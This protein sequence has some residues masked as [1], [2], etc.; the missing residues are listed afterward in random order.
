MDVAAGEA[1]SNIRNGTP[2]RAHRSRVAT[3]GARAGGMR[4]VEFALTA[5]RPCEPLMDRLRRG[6]TAL[7]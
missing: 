2:G 4:W 1:R 6:L 3:A 7:A 5:A